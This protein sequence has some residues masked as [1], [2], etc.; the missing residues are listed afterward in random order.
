MMYACRSVDS[1]QPR[2]RKIAQWHILPTFV[3]D[4]KLYG[5]FTA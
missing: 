1:E 3:T 5:K 2:V 4:N